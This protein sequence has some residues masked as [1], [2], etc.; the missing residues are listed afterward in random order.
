MNLTWKS[1]VLLKKVNCA[2]LTSKESSWLKFSSKFGGKITEASGSVCPLSKSICDTQRYTDWLMT[3]HSDN[4]PTYWT[5]QENSTWPGPGLPFTST[6]GTAL[7]NEW[8]QTKAWVSSEFCKGGKM[9]D[10]LILTKAKW[11]VYK[12]VNI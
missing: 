3:N 12:S 1:P 10:A 8:L 4:Y 2:L 7:L 5:R 6:V 11:E 9:E